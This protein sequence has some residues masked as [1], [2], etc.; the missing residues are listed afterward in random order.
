TDCDLTFVLTK[1]GH[2]GGIL[3][4]PGHPDRH[5]RIGHRAPGALY[6]GPD[7]WFAAHPSEPG[8]WWP[9]YAAWLGRKNK[10]RVDPPQMG[11]SKAGF[12]PICPAPGTY[13]H[14][15]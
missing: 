7:P 8:S 2:N 9:T 15:M 13:V 12:A 10:T 6:V 11:N 1:G 14:Q 5:F 3:S 4:E